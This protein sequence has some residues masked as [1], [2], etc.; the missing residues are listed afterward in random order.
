MEVYTD[1]VRWWRGGDTM[2]GNLRWIANLFRRIR[3]INWLL[4]KHPI[5]NI[6]LV[7]AT[8]VIFSTNLY[9][10]SSYS[11]IVNYALFA[12]TQ[13]NETMWQEQLHP[14]YGAE[15]TDLSD[16]K[17]SAGKYDVVLDG[18]VTPMRDVEV[19]RAWSQWDEYP[20]GSKELKKEFLHNGKRYVA[21]VIYVK[22]KDGKGIFEFEL[23]YMGG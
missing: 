23:D 19:N 3:I 6:I 2:N 13:N 5:A 4:D 18:R 1:S 15:L 11:K 12:Y 22:D 9:Y 16:L 17:A 8:V 20:K 21:T 14:V 10:Q 7:L